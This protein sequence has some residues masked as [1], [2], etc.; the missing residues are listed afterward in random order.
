MSYALYSCR[1]TPDARPLPNPARS[2]TMAPAVAQTELSFGNRKNYEARGGN[3]RKW[4]RGKRRF[5]VD[6][7]SGV[8]TDSPG[9]LRNFPP[10]PSATPQMC[11]PAGSGLPQTDLVLSVSSAQTLSCPRQRGVPSFA[12][13][14]SRRCP[15]R[16]VYTPL[17]EPIAGRFSASTYRLD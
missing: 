13:R 17:R 8:V 4:R 6:W 9:G 3:L 15:A 10:S 12:N 14:S 7:G 1:L 16:L 11:R 2:A 5:I